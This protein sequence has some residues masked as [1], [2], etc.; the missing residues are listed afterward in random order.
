MTKIIVIKCNINERGVLMEEKFLNFMKDNGLSENTYNSYLSD[1]KIFKKYYLD[2]YGEDLTTLVHA[3]IKMYCSH[4]IKIGR[5]VH[6]INRAI[7]A[8][9]QYN[10]FLID[11]KIQQDIVII[12]KDYIKVQKSIV[13]KVLPT[14]QELN[15]LKHSA[16]RDNKN[17]KRDFCLISIFIYGGLRESEIVNL[18]IIDVK[19]ENRFLDIIGKGNKFRQVVINNIMYDALSEYLEERKT[20]KTNNPYLFVGQKNIKNT[21]PLRRNFCN[22]LL[23]KYKEL[24]NIKDLHPHLLRSF[25]CTNALHNAGYSIDQVANQAGHSSLNTTKGYL[26][27]NQKD[28]ISLA[29]NL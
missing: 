5:S 27:T 13:Q 28:L 1:I 24:C 25:F 29:N 18:R 15:K 11:Q 7:A 17:S 22:R 4:M 6:T 9:K 20:M 23:N 2:S 8:I 12:D 3:D 10:L 21:K 16:C 19:L 14:E 26:I